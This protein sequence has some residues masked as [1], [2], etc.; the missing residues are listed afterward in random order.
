M[1]SMKMQKF[2]TLKYDIFR[3]VGAQYA[4]GDQLR[5]NP[6]K[7]EETEPKGK[8]CLVV[9]VMGNG[10]KGRC[11]TEQYCIGYLD[12]RSMKQGKLELVKQ[13]MA[14]VNMNILRISE[15]KWING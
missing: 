6:I 2:G 3:S 8:Q 9:D 4:S 1:N 13:E 5:T 14:R 15:L 12:V 10:S 11:F 7:N